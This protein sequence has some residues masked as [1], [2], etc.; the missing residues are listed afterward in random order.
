MQKK[1]STFFWL[2]RF[3]AL[4]AMLVAGLTGVAWAQTVAI[5]SAASF[6]TRIAPE[7]LASVFGESLSGGTFFGT[8]TNPGLPGIQLPTSLGG[9]SVDIGGRPCGLLFVSPGQVNLYVP[10]DVAVGT[11]NVLVRT[12]SGNRNTTIGVTQTAPGVFTFNGNGQGVVAGSALRV[13]NGNGTYEVIADLSG[14]SYITRPIDLGPASDQ[15]FLVFFGTGWRRGGA[16]VRVL[17]GGNEIT[18]QFAGA[19]PDLVGLD[20]INLLIPR[21]LIGIGKIA[22]AVTT[23]GEA[24]SNSVEAEIA[25]VTSSN[26]PVVTAFAPDVTQA[27]QTITINGSGFSGNVAGNEVRIGGV[28]AQVLAASANQLTVRVPYGGESGKVLV[29]TVNGDGLSNNSLRVRTSLS[30]LVESTDR[31]ALNNVTVRSLTSGLR[32]ISTTTGTNGLFVLSEFLDPQSGNALVTIDGSKVPTT[33][34]FGTLSVNQNYL[35]ARDTQFGNPLTLQQVSGSA[36][37]VGGGLQAESDEPITLSQP[38]FQQIDN[39]VIRLGDVTFELPRDAPVRFPD[40]STSGQIVLTVIENARLPVRFPGPFWASTVV[41]ITPFGVQFGKGGRMRFPNP[42]SYPANSRIV[43]C[44]FDQ[45]EKSPTLGS[46]I[47]PGN[48][49]VSADGRW[50]DTDP[51][52]IQQGAI[53]FVVD[54]RKLTTVVGRVLD[55]D[56]SPVRNALVRVRGRESLTD[57]TGG[58]VLRNVPVGERDTLQVEAAFLRPNGRTTRAD[59]DKALAVPGG[60][61]N[62]GIISLPDP[63][64]NQPPVLVV[65]SLILTVASKGGDYAFQAFDEEDQRVPTLRVTGAPFATIVANPN[66]PGSALLRL[67]PTAN[68]IGD[69]EVTILAV[70]SAGAATAR[71]FLVRVTRT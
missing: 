55:A 62:V 67:A 37:Q 57:G 27:A 24:P 45:G 26:S 6:E 32:L 60:I 49:T 16:S 63:R 54:V 31:Q 15:V 59:S 68:Q 1:P 46:W 20:Q 36:A 18:P 44:Q 47:A 25:G 65:S 38:V 43:I 22:F 58:F 39:T 9:V 14:S 21:A 7:S 13:R 71:T 53:Y 8:D 5:T 33:P 28:T 64:L 51:G 69:F 35:S 10:G 17:M 3:P 48:A 40:G 56:R 19:Q 34:A 11:A 61:T 42:E 29:R 50:I 4:V 2:Q 70:D 41:Q 12:N 52:T 23:P 30:G 66:T